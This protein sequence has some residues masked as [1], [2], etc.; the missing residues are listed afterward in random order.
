MFLDGY[1]SLVGGSG[2]PVDYTYVQG[3][4]EGFEKGTTLKYLQPV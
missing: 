1:V 3:N 4:D 2:T